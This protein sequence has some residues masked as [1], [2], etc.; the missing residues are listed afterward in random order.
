MTP[1]SLLSTG[2]GRYRDNALID[3]W[4][5]PP[6]QERTFSRFLPGEAFSQW[7]HFPVGIPPEY[8]FSVTAFMGR[9]MPQS[10]P[11]VKWLSFC[12]NHFCK[13]EQHPI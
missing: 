13:T 4:F 12:Y 8:F 10:V 6:A 3:H 5:Q 7:P 11:V 1:Y 9:I 2:R